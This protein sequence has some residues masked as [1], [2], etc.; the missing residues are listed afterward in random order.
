MGIKNKIFGTITFACICLFAGTA[1]GAQRF[2][3]TPYGME[4]NYVLHQ[5][6]WGEIDQG[7]GQYEIKLIGEQPAGANYNKRIFLEITP[8]K[9]KGEV[10]LIPLQDTINGFE[11]RIE[12]HSFMTHG[13]KEIF[14]AMS[15][16]DRSFKNQFFIIELGRYENRFVYDSVAVAMPICKGNFRAG[17]KLRVLVLD[18]NQESFIDL[19]PRKTYYSQRGIYNAA[20]GALRRELTTWGGHFMTLEPVDVDGDKISELRGLMVMYGTGVGDPVAQI[21]SVLKYKAGGWYVVRSN[22]A[23]ASDLRFVPTP[24]KTAPAKRPARRIV[25]VKRATPAA[26]QKITTSPAQGTPINTDSQQQTTTP[27]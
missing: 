3:A 10:S 11:P 16:A 25:R 7:Q 1:F 27:Q 6:V 13:K 2:D 23:P 12:L 21:Q 26:T 19:S 22:T 24:V 4:G 14:L 9:G 18:T 17:F 5:T 8:P 20:N 15:G